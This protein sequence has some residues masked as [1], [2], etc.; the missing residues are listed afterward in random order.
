MASQRLTL[1][2]RSAIAIS[3]ENCSG[4]CN[5]PGGRILIQTN[6]YAAN[7]IIYPNSLP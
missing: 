7:K 2:N 4:L 6:N 5:D 3:G 1:A